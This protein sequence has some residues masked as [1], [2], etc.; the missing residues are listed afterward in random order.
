ME[1]NDFVAWFIFIVLV[2]IGNLVRP[3]VF[4]WPS[5][6]VAS[7]NLVTSLA[8][9]GWFVN[10]A[11]GAGALFKSIEVLTGIK[12]ASGSQFGWQFVHGI[13]TVI[14]SQA[15]GILG[16]ADWGRYT[17]HPGS[18]RY[19]QGLGMGLSDMYTVSCSTR[20][21]TGTNLCRQLLA[22]FV[23]PALQQYILMQGLS[24]TQRCF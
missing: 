7:V 8:M 22:S 19:P 3:E 15:T 16:F 24:G 17:K 11:S 20:S 14:A 2:A 6:V 9:L 21:V 10:K 1:T 23:L 13:T 4:H 5:I 18:Q 12:P